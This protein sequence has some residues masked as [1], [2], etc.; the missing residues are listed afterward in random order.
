MQIKP[1]DRF[2][3]GQEMLAAFLP[4]KKRALKLAQAKRASSTNTKKAVSRNKTTKK[5]KAVKLKI[6]PYTIQTSRRVA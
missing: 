3:N 1:K 4:L 6:N 2:H 5:S